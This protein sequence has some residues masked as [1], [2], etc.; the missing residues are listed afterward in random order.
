MSRQAKAPGGCNAE[1]QKQ[2][3]LSSRQRPASTSQLQQTQTV[4]P[5]AAPRRFGDWLVL[6]VDAVGER[7]VASCVFC[8][9]VHPLAV[10]ALHEGGVSKCPCTR[11]NRSRRGHAVARIAERIERGRSRQHGGR[12]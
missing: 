2:I 5:E 10:W 1:G 4:S 6:A 9:D 11:V 12:T 3:S 8:G 7:A